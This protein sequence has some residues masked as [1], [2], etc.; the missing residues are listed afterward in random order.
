M[1]LFYTFG[2]MP[3]N[4]SSN[5]HTLITVLF[6]VVPPPLFPLELLPLMIWSTFT[7]CKIQWE[8]YDVLRATLV[9]AADLM[10]GVALPFLSV[11]F[12]LCL[13]EGHSGWVASGVLISL[14]YPAP[15]KGKT[16]GC[17]K[18]SDCAL[19]G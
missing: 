17:F 9:N 8:A 15:S 6:V 10:L 1:P 14:I 16:F 2:Y 19:C 18:R 13:G 11:S 12:S 4:I 5:P 3:F 7:L